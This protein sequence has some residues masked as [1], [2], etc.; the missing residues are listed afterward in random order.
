MQLSTSDIVVILIYMV[1]MLTF[2][3]VYRKYA[4]RNL[5]SFF[6]GSRNIPW[7]LAGASMIASSFAADTP[8]A[9]AEI[10]NKNGIAGNWI[11]WNALAGGMLTTFF[12]SR[13]W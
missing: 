5:S 4:G 7:W 10:V 6:L 12:F 13:M 3:I 9:V 2:G 11:W 1:A 8:L